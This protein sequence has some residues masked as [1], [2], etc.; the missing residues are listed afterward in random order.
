M[1]R[2]EVV[3]AVREVVDGR[4]VRWRSPGGVYF[5]GAERT[6][7]IYDVEARDQLV[8]LK[9]LREMRTAIDDAAGGPVVYIFYTPS[10]SR[11]RRARLPAS[12]LAVHVPF[13]HHDV[14]VAE[15]Q[16]L[17]PRVD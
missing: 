2:D 14:A 16:T 12:I 9:G 1:T 3:S 10:Q 5:D 17:S 6:L 11:V 15:N 4:H 7:E 8:L 13:R